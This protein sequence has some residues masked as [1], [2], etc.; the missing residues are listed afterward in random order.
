[1]FFG[2]PK[3]KAAWGIDVSTKYGIYASFSHLY[4]DPQNIAL[5]RLTN[6]PETFTLR[7]ASSYNLLNTK[8]GFRRSLF[9]SF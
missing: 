3:V 8:I 5:E 1:M 2:V 6:N 4:K 9:F 7:T